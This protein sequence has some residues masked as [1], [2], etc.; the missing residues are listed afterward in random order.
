MLR[1]KT[2]D[3]ASG[4]G[5]CPNR[6]LSALI[7]LPAA[8]TLLVSLIAV[9]AHASE[10]S[11][12]T[13]VG[14]ITVSG[15]TDP[16]SDNKQFNGVSADGTP[17]TNGVN[18][19]SQSARVQLH[20]S[21]WVTD[22]GALEEGD[23]VSIDGS[24]TANSHYALPILQGPTHLDDA[25]SNRIFAVSY[26]ALNRILL[27]RTGNPATGR[28]DFTLNLSPTDVTRRFNSRDVLFGTTSTWTVGESTVTINN[29]PIE[30]NACDTVFSRSSKQT[31][32]FSDRS[33]YELIF[34][35]CLPIDR[36]LAEENT[37]AS[38]APIIGFAHITPG[39]GEITDIVFN[40]LMSRWN[41]AYDD[42]HVGTGANDFIVDR[43]EDLGKD[44]EIHNWED[45]KKNLNPGEYAIT[46]NDDGTYDV[47]VNLGSQQGDN[48]IL[49]HADKANTW[50]ETTNA[51]VNK[52]IASKMAAQSTSFRV[53]VQYADPNVAGT[54]LADFSLG[55]DAGDLSQGT[56]AL[57]NALG[58]QSGVGQ[59]TVTYDGNGAESGNVQPV[60]ADPET[61]VTVAENGFTH[62]GFSFVGWNTKPDG[63]GTAYQ[64]GADIMAPAEGGMTVLYA[65]WKADEA[66]LRYDKNADK[67]TGE[68]PDTVGV[69]DQ[70]VTVGEN[71]YSRTGYTFAGWNTK[72]NGQGDTVQPGS[73]HTLT[74]G[75]ATLYAQWNANRYT[76]GFDSNTG[77][78]SMDDQQFVYDTEQ[79][80]D[81]NK[82]TKP[83]YTFTGWNTSKTGDGDG[84][85]DRQTV[86]NL[87][88]D[89]GGRVVLYAQ[90]EANPSRV[91]YDKNS[92]KATGETADTVGV[93]D[94][95]VTVSRNGYQR[96]GYTFTGWNTKADGTGDTYQPDGQ[97]K[98][99]VDHITLYAQ[100]TANP[101]LLT[102]DANADDAE[103]STPD[104]NTYYDKTVKLQ[105]NGYR[106]HGYTF[107]GWNTQPDGSGT[108]YQPEAKYKVTF[109]QTFYAQWQ[110][111][112]VTV[113]Y[114]PNG[115]DGSMPRLTGTVG[116]VCTFHANTYERPGYTFTGWNTKPEGDGTGYADGQTLTCPADPLLLY[117]QW[118]PSESNISYN[119]NGGTGTTP[120]TTGVTDQ[121]VTVS[122]N[123]FTRDGYTFLGWNSEPDGTGYDYQPGGDYQLRPTPTILY[124]QWQ[125]Q[126]AT[127]DYAANAQD[128]TGSTPQ[129]VS[130]QGEPVTVNDN[131]Y[132]RPGY[133][134]AG[135]NTQPDGTG[136]TL[137]PGAQTTL[138]PG[139]NTTVYAQWTP[140]PST[141]VYDAN[142][143]QATGSTEPTTG[144]TGQQVEV[145]DNGYVLDGYTFTGWNTKADGT[146]DTIQ[147]GDTMTAPVE[148]VTLY[149]QWQ[150]N[151][152]TLT[153]D[154]NGGEGETPD[155]EGV[156]GQ[157]I[158][159]PAN[160]FT[161]DG[162]TFTGWNTAKDGTGVGYQPDDQYTL[163]AGTGVMYAQW[164]PDPASV[165]F[166]PNGGTGSMDDMH[167]VTDE[168]SKLTKNTFE[169]G[170][171]TFA[172]WNTK[173]D[174]SG[175]SYEDE[176]DWLMRGD[177]T[178]YAQWDGDPA[179][180]TPAQ[181][182][183]PADES[184]P[185]ALTG[186]GLFGAAGALL[187][188]L[189]IAAAAWLASRRQ[190][191]GRHR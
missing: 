43:H 8:L 31:D 184:K 175:L 189:L 191:H 16:N 54:A 91:Q 74:P 119:A 130:Q 80:L 60:H 25:H 20:L 159:M 6:L 158:G 40:S 141:I 124:A 109:N 90:W 1:K 110:G 149:A 5:G 62:N 46:G 21:G 105:A 144:V 171:A 73:Q 66:R 100:W 72:A 14:G 172:G 70:Q 69:T 42:T 63:T 182:E 23:T 48:A 166:D 170:C 190:P 145:N 151:P 186:I 11:N 61:N 152:A 47:A 162:Y 146:G 67:A 83:G 165:R 160:G 30:N 97:L 41:L 2:T 113:D 138:H 58:S 168:Q 123:G 17:I 120:T 35:Q 187:V 188:S 134:F 29:D 153:F 108:A 59:S 13:Q 122:Q 163:S 181:P 136:D 85:E 52:A 86:V 103:G 157:T 183:K 3:V 132:Q 82:F 75:V 112:P 38:D 161:L 127:L 9:P 24:Y 154:G 156:T 81:A 106:R 15:V 79:K 37:G 131:G 148:G 164:T 50:D 179:C 140:L 93:T 78:G 53:K 104:I 185:L 51:I 27:T 116:G 178:L 147:P 26:P 98:L 96:E 143:P 118:T 45:A 99:P 101:A 121:I 167:G 102:F 71:G 129:T 7:A 169:N 139:T 92:D 115:G 56:V 28:Y 117:A 173:P 128:A 177:I 65:Q 77:T 155:I 34:G 22:V 12:I 55:S 33:V 32:V 10:N 137:Q 176:A 125:A 133:T 107:T 180:P 76:V 135:W 44:I 19:D 18:A 111:N 84:Y 57:S 126:P 87:T 142:H 88:A 36:M 68:T 39:Q 174:G 114:N 4:G 64:P 49:T 94:Q 95:T 150:A 89:N